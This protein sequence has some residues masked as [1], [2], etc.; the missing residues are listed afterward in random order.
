MNDK[1]YEDDIID[2]DDGDSY[3]G[4][5]KPGEDFS[6]TRLVMS[7]LRR[8]QEVGA[9]EKRPG[10]VAQKTDRNGNNTIIKIY[11]DTRKEFISSV[12]TALFVIRPDFIQDGSYEQPCKKIEE[13][14][15]NLIK[16]IDTKE[17]EIIMIEK[18]AWGEMIRQRKDSL[19]NQGIFPIKGRIMLPELKEEMINFQDEVWGEIF[20]KLHLLTKTIGYYGE[21]EHYG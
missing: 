3:I 14:I 12:K 11:P 6:H 18:T 1:K 8:C 21:D 2:V 20:S 19:I 15:D 5:G 10:W 7:C 4:G 13:E 16:N 17:K 9:Q